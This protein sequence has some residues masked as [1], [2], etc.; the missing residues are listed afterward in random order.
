MPVQYIS[1]HPSIYIMFVLAIHKLTTYYDTVTRDLF[2][3][4]TEDS[5][6]LRH[7]RWASTHDLCKQTNIVATFVDMS[8]ICTRHVPTIVS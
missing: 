6:W 8:R 3:M 7:I 5:R 4:E 2:H 1:Q